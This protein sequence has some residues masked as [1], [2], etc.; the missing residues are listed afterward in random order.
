MSSK[1]RREA[2]RRIVEDLAVEERCRGREF[3]CV[4]DYGCGTGWFVSRFARRRS[5]VLGV[6]VQGAP[7]AAANRAREDGAL[8]VLYGGGTLPIRSESVDL[9]LGV[10]V[11][12]SLLDRGPLREAVAEWRRCL[13]P[14]GILLLV[15]TDNAAFRRYMLPDD[16]REAIVSLGMEGLAWYPVRKAGWWGLNLVKLGVIPP[17]WYPRLARWEL[18]ARRKARTGL[19][20]CAYLGE[21]RKGLGGDNSSA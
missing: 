19:G 16:L 7:L 1:M 3:P 2:Y 13:K 12:R 21:F 11:V 8:F 10:G 6:E 20:K 9:V 14:G 4:L 15:E 18:G 17:S 5:R